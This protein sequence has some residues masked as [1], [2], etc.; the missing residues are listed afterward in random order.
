MDTDGSEYIGD[1]AYVKWDGNAFIV[2]THNG[3]QTTNKV[4][5]EIPEMKKLIDFARATTDRIP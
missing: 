3:I 5:L 2:F 4:Y 1:G